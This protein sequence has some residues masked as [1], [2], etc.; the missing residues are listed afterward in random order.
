MFGKFSINNTEITSQYSD[1]WF[2]EEVRQRV[3][4]MT[5]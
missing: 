5:G 1:R 2:G 3:E 4:E